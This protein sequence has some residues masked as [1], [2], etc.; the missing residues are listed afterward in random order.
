MK[1]RSWWYEFTD[2]LSK[3]FGEVLPTIAFFALVL[4]ALVLIVIMFWKA[5][6]LWITLKIISA[7]L[8]L[9]ILSA[10]LLTVINRMK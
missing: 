7:I 4:C 5:G 3:V 1:F 6:I 9:S 8:L 2:N 10:A